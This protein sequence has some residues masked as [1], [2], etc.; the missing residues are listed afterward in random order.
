MNFKFD[1]GDRVRVLDGSKIEYFTGGWVP[2]MNRT[3]GQEAKITTLVDKYGIP[4]YK[5]EFE[6]KD[7]HLF[8]KA[9]FDERGLEL[10]D[11]ISNLQFWIEGRTVHCEAFFGGFDKKVMSE[12]T[13]HPDDEFDLKTGMNIALDRLLAKTSM[14]NGKVIC[15]ENNGHMRFAFTKGKIYT[16]ANGEIKVQLQTIGVMNMRYLNS[17]VCIKISIGKKTILS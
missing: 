7:L 15:V 3:I 4:A 13:C 9:N 10:V 14:Y 17:S 5:L 1:I 6:N 2:V 11:S 8:N 16:I 12:A